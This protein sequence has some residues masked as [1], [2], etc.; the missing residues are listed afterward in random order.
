VNLRQLLLAHRNKWCVIASSWH[1]L[2][3]KLL[4]EVAMT[5]DTDIPLLVF[6]IF[7]IVFYF[8]SN[9]NV[10]DVA[11]YM[12]LQSV[13]LQILFLYK[14]Y[15]ILSALSEYPITPFLSIGHH[16]MYSFYLSIF[17]TLLL[18]L[19]MPRVLRT[20][21]NEIPTGLR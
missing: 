9:Y 8:T 16:S 15:D 12:N 1:W 13:T 5:L 19:L 20:I 18:I 2:L 4:N 14:K 11:A 21:E 7:Y 17:I 10:E 3:R 6:F